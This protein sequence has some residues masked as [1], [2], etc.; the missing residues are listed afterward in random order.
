MANDAWGAICDPNTGAVAV[1]ATRA[2]MKNNDTASLVRV[3]DAA[4]ALL[5]RI[6]NLTTDEFQLGGERI[7][8]EA[9]RAALGLAR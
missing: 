8:R 9:L 1:K 7:E 4:A 6:D 5:A 3:R 2:A